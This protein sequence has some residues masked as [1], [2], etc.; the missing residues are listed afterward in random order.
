M[1]ARAFGLIQLS[2]WN[3]ENWI[4]KTWV[5]KSPSG[6]LFGPPEPAGPGETRSSI[7]GSQLAHAAMVISMTTHCPHDYF[8]DDVPAQLVHS[9]AC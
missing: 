1:F 8:R 2:Q 6:P 5:T 3:S 7:A 9:P 4:L